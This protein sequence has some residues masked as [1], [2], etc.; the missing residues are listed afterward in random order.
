MTTPDGGP[1][2]AFHPTHVVPQDGLPAWEAPGADRPTA[3]LDPLLPVRLLSRQGDW[4]EVLCS[5]GWS[6]WVDGR[7]LVA[8]PQPP[9]TAGRPLDRTEDPEPLLAGTADAL[10]RYRQAAGGP[11]DGFRG[12]VRG[13][14]AGVVIDG[15]S[16][17]VYDAAAGRWMYGEGGRLGT[18]AVDAG[19]G[20]P[21]APQPPPGEGDAAPRAG[22]RE[23]PHPPTRTAWSTGTSNPATSSSRR[24]PTANTPSTCT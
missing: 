21:P 10:E 2:A 6:A 18:Y 7:L 14:R 9:P 4:G 17:W 22:V 12:A 13:L 23:E 15:E 11:A 8:V 3:P 20:A 19:P 16:V 5:N 1:D 24:A